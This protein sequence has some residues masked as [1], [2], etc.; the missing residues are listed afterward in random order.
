MI[1]DIDTAQL[2]PSIVIADD[3]ALTE[4]VFKA[5]SLQLVL[6]EAEAHQQAHIE[7]A[8]KAYDDATRE[9]AQ[10]IVEIFA[11]IEAYAAAHRDRLFPLK[12]G[13]RSKTFAVLQHKLQYRSSDQVEAPKDAVTRIQR[14]LS[15]VRQEL[16]T[17]STTREREG[18]LEVLEQTLKLLLRT[19]EPELNKENV[20]ALDVVIPAELGIR[21]KTSETFKLAF[22]FTPDQQP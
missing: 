12:S 20:K 14:M 1:L 5:A 16:S 11:S 18:E 19:P 3:L 9:H 8:K 21:I 22:T 15:D 4:A 2:T 7:A 10:R 17:S 6:N 13:K